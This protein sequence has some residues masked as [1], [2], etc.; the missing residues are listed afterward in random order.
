MVETILSIF[1][2]QSLQKTKW[3]FS[4]PGSRWYDVKNDDNFSKMQ[5]KVELVIIMRKFYIWVADLEGSKKLLSNKKL[6]PLVAEVHR[7]VT[8]T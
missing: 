2:F 8:H 1:C 7:K 5:Q 6:N 4:K 3:S